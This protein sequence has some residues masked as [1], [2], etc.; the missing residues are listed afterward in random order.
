[1]Q[2]GLEHS[3]LGGVN[4]WELSDPPHRFAGKSMES[5]GEQTDQRAKPRCS[6]DGSA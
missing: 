3:E 4:P 2:A 1:M 6:M 5:A